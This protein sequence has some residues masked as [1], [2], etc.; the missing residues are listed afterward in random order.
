LAD[1][2]CARA[3]LK[4]GNSIPAIMPMMAMTTS[5]SINVKPRIRAL[6][7][8]NF[9]RPSDAGECAGFVTNRRRDGD[10]VAEN[11]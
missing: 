10:V 9:M 11:L 6:A 8:L 4:A 2:P 5:N 1:W 7:C 3:L